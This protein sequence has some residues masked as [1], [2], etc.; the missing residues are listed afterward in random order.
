MPLSAVSGRP[1]KVPTPNGYYRN[2]Y[3]GATFTGWT[4]IPLLYFTAGDKRVPRLVRHPKVKTS[5]T[6]SSASNLCA[7]CLCSY[8]VQFLVLRR[9]HHKWAPCCTNQ[10]ENLVS[11]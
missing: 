2:S 8:V 7:N 9:G 10:F 1:K 6:I 11:L 4:R 3:S 5:C